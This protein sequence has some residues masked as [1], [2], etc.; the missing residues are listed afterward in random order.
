V[1]HVFIRDHREEFDV[2]VM[3]DVL[4]VTDSGFYAWLK[5]PESARARRA[6]E[7]TEEIRVV[8]QENRR[9]YGSIKVQQ[10][11]LRRGRKVNRKTVARLM[12]AAGIRAKVCRKFRVCTTDS[13]HD[14]PVAP[15]L[16]D[17]QFQVEQLDTVWAT[18]ITYIHTDEGVLYLAGIMDLCSRKIIGWSMS[19]TMTADLVLSAMGMAVNARHPDPGLM[20]H[21]DRGVQYTC[22]RY[23]DFLSAR[24]ITLSMSRTGNCYDNAVVESFWGKLKNEMVHHERFAT[25]AQ[26]RAA[27]FDYIEVFYNRIRLHAALGYVSPEEFE[28]G[29]RRQ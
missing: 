8:H 4:G 18:D 11:L 19:D 6:R 22:E 14:N 23:R 2:S 5:R 20:H 28:A 21:S 27:I 13:D 3:C 7:L 10:A 26:A 15:N 17:R 12:Q 24:G 16:L 9:V 29:R 25:R 1:K